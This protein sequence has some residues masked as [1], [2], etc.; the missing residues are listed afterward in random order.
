MYMN[1]KATHKNESFNF[2]SI[3][4]SSRIVAVLP[5]WFI[6]F[7]FDFFLSYF[8]TSNSVYGLQN[9]KN[10]SGLYPVVYILRYDF[11]RIP[12]GVLNIKIKMKDFE[13]IS[14]RIAHILSQEGG[15]CHL[16][17]AFILFL[18]SSVH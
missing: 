10:L 11:W 18:S 17:E 4:T 7:L 14:C 2:T 1:D 6:S 16:L 9:T 3:F 5:Y 8:I 12:W 15:L 13:E